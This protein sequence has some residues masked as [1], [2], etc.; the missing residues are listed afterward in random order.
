M[1]L[2]I[3]YIDW[4]VCRIGKRNYSVLLIEYK[5]VV[6]EKKIP[7]YNTDDITIS[8]DDSGE[9]NEEHSNEKN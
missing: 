8:S 7:E 1:Y 2:S 5:C 3:S 4:F 9:E 6:K